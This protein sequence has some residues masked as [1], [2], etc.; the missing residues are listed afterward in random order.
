MSAFL[1]RLKNAMRRRSLDRE[2][3]GEIAAH[4]ALAEEEYRHRGL[5]A[6]DARRA[7]LRDFG[8]VAFAKEA[9]RDVRGFPFLESVWADVRYGLRG[10]CRTPAATAVMVVTLALGIGVTTAIFSAVDAVFLQ[11]APVASPD[12][13]VDVYTRHTAAPT[14]NATEGDQLSTSSYPDYMDLRNSQVLQGLAAFSQ[15]PLTLNHGGDTSAF[16]AQIVSGNYFAILGVEAGAG[17]LLRDDDDRLDAPSRVVVISNRLWRQRF[18]GDPAVVGQELLL[19]NR[20]HTVIG[21]AAAGFGGTEIGE[22]VDAWVP[23]ALQEEVRPMS[24][25]MQREVG[26][27]SLLVPK[28]RIARWLSLVGRLDDGQTLESAA[29]GLDVIGKQ[30]AAAYPA[31]NRSLSATAVPLGG[32][33]GIR[34]SARPVLNMLSVAVMLVLLIACANVAGLLLARA[35]SRRREVAVRIALGASRGR[36]VRQWITEAIM[37]GSVGSVAGLLIATWAMPVLH[38]LGVFRDLEFSLN[39]RVLLFA[40]GCGAATGFLFGLAPIRQLL[41]RNTTAAL[42]DEGGAVVTGVHATRLRSA[43]VIVQVALSLMLLVGAGLFIRSFQQALRVNLGYRV[44]R[45]L[46]ATVALPNDYTPEKGQVFYRDLLDRLQQVPGIAAA[47]AARVTVLSGSARTTLVSSDGQPPRPDN[48]NMMPVRANVVTDRYFE[49]LGIAVVR[50][51]EF[52]SSDLPTAP[53]VAVVSESL[54]RRLWGD[55]DPLGKMLLSGAPKQVVGVVPDTVYRS[56]AEKNPPPVLYLPLTQNYENGVTLHIKTA[57][58]PVAMLPTVRAAVRQ[59]EPR[60]A[61]TQPRRLADEYANSTR[62]QRTLATLAGAL[63]GIAM[64]L[65]ALGLYG[66]MSYSARQ[67]MPEMGVRLALGATPARIQRLVVVGGARLVAYGAVLGLT[68]AVALVGL[69][70]AQLFGVEPSDPITWIGVALL[71]LVV[72]AIACGLPAHRAGRT[73]PMQALRAL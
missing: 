55:A 46:L 45:M 41:R 61:V 57:G 47:S 50:G 51:R 64:L 70:R 37:L 7:A 24:G 36:L 27:K 6:A 18:G 28:A 60:V 9:E 23:M 26:V 69:V 71:M 16:D 53:R 62:T 63:S 31:T 35:V 49:G 54:A 44:D 20:P 42:R 22:P 17:R 34:V 38:G 3:D 21:V 15:V 56:A 10:A 32:G 68:G 2:M 12:R 39:S 52:L 29:A 11:S 40:L 72:G 33:P 14:A 58:D 25:G 43:F 65:A 66:V 67:R 30:L 73:S 19:N 48:S 4:L 8:G 59:L 1:A 5:T 13:L